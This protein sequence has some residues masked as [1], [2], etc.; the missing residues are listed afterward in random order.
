MI[1]LCPAIGEIAFSVKIMED[2]VLST[3]DL[4]PVLEYMELLLEQLQMLNFGVLIL[5]GALLGAM[6]IIVLAVMFR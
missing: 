1:T 2:S 3:V 6:V 4:A 5:T